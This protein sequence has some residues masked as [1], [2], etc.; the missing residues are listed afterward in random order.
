MRKIA[1]RRKLERLH[2]LY[3]CAET[4]QLPS[5]LLLPFSYPDNPQRRVLEEARDVLPFAPTSHVVHPYNLP[6]VGQGDRV[7][8]HLLGGWEGGRKGGRECIE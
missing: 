1:N 5:P 2:V 7:H 6:R 3:Q 4:E 8:P